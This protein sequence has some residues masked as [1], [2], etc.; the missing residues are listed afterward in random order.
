MEALGIDLVS[1]VWQIVAFIILVLLMNRLLFRPIRK[2]MDERAERVRESMEEA[3]RI[4]QQ[5]VRADE[6]YEARL[7]EAQNRA[8]E[9]VDQARERAR[10]EHEEMLERA[11]DEARQFLEDA[12]AEIELERRDMAREARQQVAGLTVLAAGRLIGETLDLEKHRDLVEKHVVELDEPLEELER[13]LAGVAPGEIRAVQVRSAIP[14]AEQTQKAVR[15]RV[16]RFLGDGV[17]VAFGTDADLIGGLTLQ[18]GDQVVDL[19][20][21]RK[22]NDLFR[23]VAA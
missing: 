3:E 13:A 15:D 10:Q 4:K 11:H 1:L 6:D 22:L 12:R 2:A 17:E 9:L 23:E 20:V 21:A 16:A 19:S 18:V 14:L 7:K 5:A 8:Q